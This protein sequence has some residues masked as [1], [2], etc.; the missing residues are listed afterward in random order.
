LIFKTVRLY[1][2]SPPH[3]QYYKMISEITKM[4]INLSFCLDLLSDTTLQH[5]SFRFKFIPDVAYLMSFWSLQIQR[6]TSSIMW[7]TRLLCSYNFKDQFGYLLNN[8]YELQ[9]RVQIC[10]NLICYNN[11]KL[12]LLNTSYIN[13]KVM[14]QHIQANMPKYCTY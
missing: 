2:L 7:T 3:Y 13:F 5:D 1:Q 9:E 12:Y 8:I 4:L 14:F 11:H 6:G 10:N